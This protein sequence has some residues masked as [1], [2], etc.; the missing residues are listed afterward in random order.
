MPSNPDLAC[1]SVPFT[2]SETDS[3]LANLSLWRKPELSPFAPG[4]ERPVDLTLVLDRGPSMGPRDR[5]ELLATVQALVP[6][7]VHVALGIAGLGE[8][9]SMNYG[10][11]DQTTE[12]P[13]LGRHTGTNLLFIRSMIVHRRY[14]F[15]LRYTADCYPVRPNWLGRLQEAFNNTPSFLMGPVYTG[16]SQLRADFQRHINAHSVYQPNHELFPAYLLY[17]VDAL[18]AAQAESRN[19]HLTYEIAYDYLLS[20]QSSR[21][22]AGSHGL[23]RDARRLL[24]YI[25]TTPLMANLSG[26]RERDGTSSIDIHA[27]LETHQHVVTLHS[28]LGKQYHDLPI[29]S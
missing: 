6:A 10:D 8:Q 1:I 26:P 11:H 16:D 27:Y 13:W 29:A 28:S 3:L 24:P 22:T 19:S 9:E 5:A 14:G 15:L 18:V 12:I 4:A 7:Y 2:A 23:L 21:V 20:V 17:V 25:G